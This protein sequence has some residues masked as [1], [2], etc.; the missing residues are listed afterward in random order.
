MRLLL[1]THVLLWLAEESHHLPREVIDL[2]EDSA[3]DL[4]FSVASI[5]EIAIKAGR[6][7]NFEITPTLLR[8]QLLENGYEEMMID[9]NHALMIG[10]LP[11]IHGDPFDR[12]LIAQSFVEAIPLITS[13][14]TVA[15]YGGL[16][17]YI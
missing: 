4:I 2:V 16:I 8:T 14:K 12:M 17:R 13:D 7:P 1:D 15:R 3:N 9:G 11:A 5:W 6:R 10:N